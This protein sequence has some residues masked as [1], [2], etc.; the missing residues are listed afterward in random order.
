GRNSVYFVYKDPLHLTT[1]D[2]SLLQIIPQSRSIKTA[3]ITKNKLG[4]VNGT[5]TKH[6]STHANYN[7]WIRTNYT[8]LRWILHSLF[9]PISKS[10]T[11]RYNQFNAPFLYQLRKHIL[12]TIQGGD[13]VATCYA[14]LK[15]LWD[16]NINLINFLMGLDKKH[17]NLRCQ[18][19]A[20]EPL[21]TINQ[22]FAKVHQAEVQRHIFDNDSSVDF[23]GVTMSTVWRRDAKKPKFEHTPYHCD[24][25]NKNGHTRE[26]FWK[27]R[28]L[29][30][31]IS[32]V[33]SDFRG[34][35][36]IGHKI[37]ANVVETLFVVEDTPCDA[38]HQLVDA[39]VDPHFV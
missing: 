26:Y 27:L 21:P 20:M 32:P 4:F 28:N 22:A 30:T 5:Y 34:G 31:K 7:D 24:F 29:K 6:A 15:S 33:H 17:E 36:S 3:L 19:L 35:T 39:S 9:G 1:G 14:R 2:Q 10:L 23:D 8:V 16:N 37:A 18:I 25:C 38:P 12:Q 13:Y 11:Y